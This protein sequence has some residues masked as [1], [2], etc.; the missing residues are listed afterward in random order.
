MEKP[1]QHIQ[2]LIIQLFCGEIDEASLQELRTWAS[3]SPDNERFLQ[4]EQELWFSSVTTKS[5]S[6]YD[7]DAAFDL[8][9]RRVAEINNSNDAPIEVVDDSSSE[10][11]LH[12]PRWARYAAIIVLFFSIAGLAFRQGQKTMTSQLTDIIIEAPQGSQTRTTLPDGTIVWLNAGSRL[13]YPQAYGL[14]DRRVKLSGEASFKVHHD[15]DLPFSVSTQAMCVNDIGTQFNLRDYPNDKNAEVILSE[16]A[17]SINNML[18]KTDETVMM[19]PGQRAVINKSTG[20]LSMSNADAANSTQWTTG[21]LVFNGESLASIA[22]KME[23]YY[24]VRVVVSPNSQNNSRFFGD[25]SKQ[26]SSINDVLNALSSTHKL[27]YRRQGNTI[28]LY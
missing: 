9:K 18:D 21:R 10:M 2:D 6:H 25:F 16:G 19:S 13:T 12:F 22:Q 7:T 24:G 17:V 26:E 28:V 27:K 1:N 23:R 3:A 8:F 15:S 5:L 4:E 14:K 11:T 20:K